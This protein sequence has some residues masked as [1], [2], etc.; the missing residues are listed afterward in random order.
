M[1]QLRLGQ[2]LHSLFGQ[3]AAGL[4][5]MGAFPTPGSV[6]QPSS[7]PSRRAA[8]VAAQK[9]TDTV[10]KYNLAVASAGDGA[11]SD[12]DFDLD[13]EVR[14]EGGSMAR[15]PV[16]P[17]NMLP[18]AVPAAS[19]SRLAPRAVVRCC[20]VDR[21]YDTARLPLWL[22]CQDEPLT[23]VQRDAHAQAQS[24]YNRSMRRINDA[25]RRG[26]KL[27]YCCPKDSYTPG[28]GAPATLK[29]SG[30]ALLNLVYDPRTGMLHSTGQAPLLISTGA[31][32]V[33]GAATAAP[34]PT[35]MITS[36]ATTV[37]KATFQ[38]SQPLQ[39]KP[40]S[41]SLQQQ[42]P[43]ARQV[44]LITGG[45]TA[46]TANSL[47]MVKVL[48]GKVLPA[49]VLQEESQ[50][51]GTAGPAPAGTPG[52]RLARPVVTCT[53]ALCRGPVPQASGRPEPRPVDGAARGAPHRPAL[54]VLPQ[55]QGP[56][57][58]GRQRPQRIQPALPGARVGGRGGGAPFSPPLSLAGWFAPLGR[59]FEWRS[60]GLGAAVEPGYDG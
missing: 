15:L 43:P 52:G 20:I 21:S 3:I 42:Q 25:K 28:T 13:A 38:G 32:A 7:R 17:T 36:V 57:A 22:E 18:K 50:Q 60:V 24:A 16:S 44:P 49:K 31:K 19:S 8:R 30:P 53:S 6:D 5:G 11:D 14:A 40:A 10:R 23:Q 51:L 27:I 26:A 48:P 35:P 29:P 47:L 2:R 12:E 55:R 37:P 41:L 59:G 34:N 9:I 45:S 54:Q 1:A 58:A 4:G 46:V 33:S 39:A 56:A